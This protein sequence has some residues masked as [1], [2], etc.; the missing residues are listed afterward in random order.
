M[1]LHGCIVCIAEHP[2]FFNELVQGRRQAKLA[3]KAAK[4]GNV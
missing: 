4:A 3:A 2:D 1:H